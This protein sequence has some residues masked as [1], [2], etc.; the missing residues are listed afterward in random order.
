M[1]GWVITISNAKKNKHSGLKT[2]PTMV[3]VKASA[4][5]NTN[6][7]GPVVFSIIRTTKKNKGDRTQI[8]LYST[9]FHC[10]HHGKS[11]C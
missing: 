9:S 11:E 5:I 8:Y 10:I 2:A 7:S 1:L 3:E 6:I 4:H